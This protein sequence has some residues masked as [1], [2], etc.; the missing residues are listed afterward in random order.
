VGHVS[1]MPGAWGLLHD[2]AG[3]PL[4]VLQSGADLLTTMGVT[5][6]RSGGTVSQR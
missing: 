2:K 1:L 4:P 5:F 6:M 3:N